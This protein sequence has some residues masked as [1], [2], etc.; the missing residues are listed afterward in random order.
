M[1]AGCLALSMFG[2]GCGDDADDDQESR[3]GA[4]STSGGKKSS[5]GAS[6]ASSGGTTGNP[7]GGAPDD[8]E[9]GGAP[10]SCST[11]LAE[12]LGPVDSV[13]TGE[14]TDLSEAEA[15]FTTLLVDASAGGYMAAAQNPYIYLSLVDGTRVDVSDLEAATSTDW[16]I[17]LK[18]D[19]LRANGGDSGAGG[20]DVAVLEG[21][22]FDEVTADAIAEAEFGFD[23]FVD[24]VS[25][26]PIVDAVGKPLTRFD[27]WYEYASGTMSLTAAPRVYLIRSSGESVYKLEILQY[28]Q[29]VDDGAGGTVQ[30]SAVYTLRYAAL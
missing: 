13:S 1:T 19:N 28:Y 22:D 5:G 26:E 2:A 3:G 16:D 6:S 9:A 7:A 24:D 15:E 12:L 23:D 25:C 10:V 8:G 18:R 11:V 29:A 17:A 27:G 20:R 14:I 4:A 21:V 30:K